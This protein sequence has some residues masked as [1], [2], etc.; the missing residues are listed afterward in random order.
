MSLLMIGK[1]RLQCPLKSRCFEK[2]A[3][4]L[5]LMGA[6]A[7]SRRY[8]RREDIF[9]ANTGNI[10]GNAG[11]QRWDNVSFCRQDEL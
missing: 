5:A 10:P 11:D 9:T 4:I 7:L 3:V 1:G 6:D 2:L 8:S